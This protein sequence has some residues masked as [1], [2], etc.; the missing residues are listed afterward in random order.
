M[1]NTLLPTAMNTDTVTLLHARPYARYPSALI[2]VPLLASP[3]PFTLPTEIWTQIFE[4]MEIGDK[5]SHLVSALLAC[6]KFKVNR[7]IVFAQRRDGE[8]FELPEHCSAF[9]LCS[10]ELRTLFFL[11]V[12]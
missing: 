10:S 3:K 2:L 11:R 12:L 8:Q 5:S 4:V 6:R 1:K 9:A 7:S